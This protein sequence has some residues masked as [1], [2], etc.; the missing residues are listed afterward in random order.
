MFL[1]QGIKFALL[2]LKV[3]LI[4]ILRKFEIKRSANTLD[5]LKFTEGLVLS[6]IGGINVIVKNENN[7]AMSFTQ[8]EVGYLSICILFR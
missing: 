6:P 5:E 3:A 7:K 1:I 4:K 2:E 8:C